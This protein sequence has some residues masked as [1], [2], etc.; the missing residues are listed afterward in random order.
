MGFNCSSI[1]YWNRKY[2]KTVEKQGSDYFSMNLNAETAV[3]VYKIV[4]IKELF[5][6]P[7]FYMKDFG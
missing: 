6:F 7:E 1:Q 3:Y 4:A 5:E 2:T